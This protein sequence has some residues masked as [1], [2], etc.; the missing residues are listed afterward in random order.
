VVFAQA[1]H[2][3]PEAEAK[4]VYYLLDREALLKYPGKDPVYQILLRMKEQLPLRSRIESF[5]TF[6]EGNRRFAIHVTNDIDS[7][8]LFDQLLGAGWRLTVTSAGD[9]EM[10]LLAER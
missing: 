8:W 2:Y 5:R 1:E 3:L 10:L 7:D 6:S 4:R 9:G